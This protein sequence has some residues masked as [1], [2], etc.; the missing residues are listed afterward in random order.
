MFPFP[1]Q[2][3]LHF[4]KLISEQFSLSNAIIEAIYANLVYI[5][6]NLPEKG[7]I[8]ALKKLPCSFYPP[9]PLVVTKYNI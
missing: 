7:L 1:K 2:F 9:H 5:N 4:P 8:S 6:N 3:E